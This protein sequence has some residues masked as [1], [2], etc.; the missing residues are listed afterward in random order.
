MA[1]RMIDVFIQQ[2]RLGE[3]ITSASMFFYA[4]ILWLPG[5]SYTLDVSGRGFYDRGVTEIMVS[6]PLAAIGVERCIALFINGSWK[7][8][9]ALRAFGSLCGA[10]WLYFLLHALVAPTLEGKV[11]SVDPMC[12]IVGVLLVAEII[13]AF[14]AGADARANK[15]HIPGGLES[16]G[17]GDWHSSG[18]DSS[19]D[20]GIPK[21]TGGGGSASQ[22]RYDAL[23]A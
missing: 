15:Q 14:R 16:I 22:N 23:S 17:W 4:A 2:G 21:D 3:W 10:L 5:N 9:P 18:G 8:T 13:A 1:T 19:G 12:G 11:A 20:R 7:R 6:V